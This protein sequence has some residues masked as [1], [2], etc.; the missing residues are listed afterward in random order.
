MD[1]KGTELW[2]NTDKQSVKK[3][4]SCSYFCSKN[5]SSSPFRHLQG[6]CN[7]S[8]FPAQSIMKCPKT[9]CAYCGVFS[10]YRTSKTCT[11]CHIE[12]GFL[13]MSSIRTSSGM[14]HPITT[15]YELSYGEMEMTQGNLSFGKGNKVSCKIINVRSGVELPEKCREL[16][17]HFQTQGT[18]VMIG[19][20]VVAYTLLGKAVDSEG[21]SFFLHDKCYNLL[22]PE[23]PNMV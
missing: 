5:K 18:P 11:F 6:R 8:N 23:R 9:F 14:S 10:C 22:L 19:G 3:T 16:A 17:L 12:E 4:I 2:E 13:A 15:F 7:P 1:L 21:R 20:G